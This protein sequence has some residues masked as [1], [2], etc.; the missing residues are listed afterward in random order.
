MRAARACLTTSLA[1]TGLQSEGDRPDSLG[2][3]LERRPRHR[4]DLVLAKPVVLRVAHD[5]DDRERRLLVAR[6][7][8]HNRLPDGVNP[9]EPPARKRLVHDD[10]RRSA[11]PVGRRE[12]SSR[13]DLH[14]DRLEVSRRHVVHSRVVAIVRPR[15]RVHRQ[16]EVAAAKQL[17]PR[18]RRGPDARDAIQCIVEDPELRRLRV[19]ID[20][21][22]RRPPLGPRVSPRS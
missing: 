4:L 18:E 7:L 17:E 3:L 1:G 19:W 8:E 13:D 6:V 11:A 12:V 10:D 14:A 20:A 16:P 22:A 2:P 5:A 15:R 9:P 21:R